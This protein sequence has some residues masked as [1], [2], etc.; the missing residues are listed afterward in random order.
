[1]KNM[2]SQLQSAIEQYHS[3]FRA[4]PGPISNANVADSSFTTA[5]YPTAPVTITGPTPPVPTG[6]VVTL[7]SRKITMSENLTLGLLG[8]LIQVGAGVQYDPSQVGLGP[9]NLNQ[10][11]P[12]RYT[13]FISAANLSWKD[14]SGGKTGHY[15][16]DAGDADDTI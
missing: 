13:P 5:N 4:Y 10:A 14:S 8:G 16:D 2:L 9:M 7:D 15:F 12:K 6:F 1:T 3:S 11:N